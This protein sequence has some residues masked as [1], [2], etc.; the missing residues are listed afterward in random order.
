MFGTS[1]C[2]ICMKEQVEILRRSFDPTVKLI[3]SRSE[4]HSMCLRKPEFHRFSVDEDKRAEK[5]THK[6]IPLTPNACL[7]LIS[8]RIQRHISDPNYFK[9]VPPDKDTLHDVIFNAKQELLQGNPEKDKP[10]FVLSKDTLLPSCATCDQAQMKFFHWPSEA[11]RHQ[12]HIAT[13]ALQAQVKIAKS[14]WAQQLAIDCLAYGMDPIKAWKAM[15]TLEKGL[16]HHHSTCCTVRMQK[17][18][19]KKAVTGKENTEVF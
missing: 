13:K 19:E 10:W 2:K 6:D 14:T 16:S 5:V 7:D 3:N 18:G 8:C 1:R 4:I 12:L 17:P 9:G 15:R 11:N